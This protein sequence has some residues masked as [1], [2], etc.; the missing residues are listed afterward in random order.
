MKAILTSDLDRTLIF[1]NRTKLVDGDYL[2]VEQVRGIDSSFMSLKTHALLTE[3]RQLIN[4][5]PVTTRSLEQYRRITVFQTDIQPEFAVTTNGG[6]V[7]RNGQVDENWQQLVATKMAGL[8]LLFQ[9][10][11]IKFATYLGD[12]SVERV[13]PVDNL[14]FVGYL[15]LKIFDTDA[16]LEFK[17]TL[18]K[19]RWTCYLQGR[20]L[21]IMPDFLTKGSAV[22]YIKSLSTYDWH[23]AAGDSQQDVSMMLIADEYFIPQHAELAQL[24]DMTI[25]SES[26]SDFSEAF[27][28]YVLAII[29]KSETNGLK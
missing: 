3:L 9:D 22:Q 6:V 10:V 8:P 21:Y 13:D 4:L 28:H 20:K 27:L 12:A 18:E 1:S 16:M 29:R 26:S 11:L 7:L 14:F 19:E 2:T 25:M 5:V 23:G 24:S 15:D 17:K